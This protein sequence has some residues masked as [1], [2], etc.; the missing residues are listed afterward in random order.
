[1]TD[2]ID[3]CPFGRNILTR[4]ALN[5]GV[6]GERLM[7]SRS[8]PPFLQNAREPEARLSTPRLGTSAIVC[9]VQ[10][11][12]DQENAMKSMVKTLAIGSLVLATQAAWSSPLGWGSTGLGS[13]IPTQSTYADEHAAS[14]ATVNGE[15][16]LGAR[17]RRMNAEPPVRDTYQ[18]EHAGSQTAAGDDFPLGARQLRERAE[19]PVR[20]TYQ[21]KHAGDKTTARDDSF[22][23]GPNDEPWQLLPGQAAYFDRKADDA[24][25]SAPENSGNGTAE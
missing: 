19:P 3:N 24:A 2:V 17:Q 8:A 20:S 7:S 6:A 1:M 12:F 4:Q 23:G 21:S 25:A 14:Q 9:G 15:F 16:P 13:I 5:G 22:P 10:S 11:T 18:A